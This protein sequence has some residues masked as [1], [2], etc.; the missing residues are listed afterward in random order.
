MCRHEDGGVV[1]D[2][3]AIIGVMLGES[4]DF[5]DPLKMAESITD[6]RTHGN[7]DSRIYEDT[8]IRTE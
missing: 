4:R 8:E 3:I 7:A 2:G 5:F 1:R 6:L